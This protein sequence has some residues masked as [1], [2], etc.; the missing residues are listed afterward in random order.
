MRNFYYNYPQDIQFD[1]GSLIKMAR[2]KIG[3]VELQ[4]TCPRC[5][6]LNPGTVRLCGNCGAP[7]P[8]DVEFTQAERQ[9]L[10][11]EKEKIAA[12]EAGADIHCPYC[13]ARNPAGSEV[14]HQ[15]GGDLREGARREAGRVLGAY[16]TGPVGQIK[17]QNCGAEN[18]DTAKACSQCGA[19]LSQPEPVPS[20]ASTPASGNRRKPLL[21]GAAAAVLVLICGGIIILMVISGRRD[22]FSG[23]VRTVDWQRSIPIEALV[24]VESSDWEDEIPVGA[25]IVSCREDVRSVDAEPVQNSVEVCGTPYTVDTGSGFGDVVQDCEYQVYD[26][27]CTYSVDEWQQVDVASA[28][29]SDYSPYWPE[30]A[31]QTGQRL[32]EDVSETYHIVFF[33]G[34]KEHLFS[35]SDLSLFQ[36]A[37]LGTE[38]TLTVNGFGVVVSIDN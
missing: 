7:Q 32:G 11:E 4:W 17:C 31:V 27:F 33:D 25:E 38:W 26:T 13:N 24:P 5:N 37:Q 21:I 35:T 34:D 9:K 10:V 1:P 15:C 23:T 30:P 12:A 18:P 6:G 28:A 20:L 2:K 14:C 36:Q 3:H 8:E 19:S 29:G 16:K 22:T